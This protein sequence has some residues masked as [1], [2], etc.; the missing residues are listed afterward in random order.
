MELTKEVLKELCKPF[1]PSQLGLKVQAVFEKEKNE[2]NSLVVPYIDARTV[3]E[4]L[5]EVV[6][7]EWHDNYAKAPSGGLECALT[8]CG[9]TRRDVGTDD[10]DTEME[11]SGYSDAFKRAAVKF[12]V[13]RYLY[14]LPK[15]YG[16]AEKRGKNWYLKDSEE[17]R[18]R[19]L[20]DG[21]ADKQPPR[22]L[23]M[24]E[25]SER[26][27]APAK[28][29]NTSTGNGQNNGQS[30]NKKTERAHPPLSPVQKNKIAE[31]MRQL[32]GEMD[33]AQLKEKV[34]KLFQENF[35]H[36]VDTATYEE[37]ARLTGQILA[38]LR[39]KPK[40]EAK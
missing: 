7:G 5:D 29:D 27:F 4:R 26:V 32:Y 24:K 1:Q 37:G 16:T 18:L 31:L 8:V 10:N 38:E 35:K 15:M 34:E 12:G 2:S 40:Q 19:Q 9:V 11:K 6:G 21:N 23:G 14:D 39:N 22:T 30:E 20:I 25:P 28:S 33:A 36:G 3:A 17:K 13:G